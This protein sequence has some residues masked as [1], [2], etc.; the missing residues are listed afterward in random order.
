MKG[1]VERCFELI[2]LSI[3][4]TRWVRKYSWPVNQGMSQQLGFNPLGTLE[5]H[6]VRCNQGNTCTQLLV[7]ATRRE[8]M[9]KRIGLLFAI[10]SLGVAAFSQTPT[11]SPTSAPPDQPK[12]EHFTMVASLPRS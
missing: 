5:P 9:K 3:G 8:H 1:L 4:K 12:P 2:G 10:C 11:P 7:H 6:G